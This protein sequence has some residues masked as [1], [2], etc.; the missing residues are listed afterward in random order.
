VTIAPHN[1]PQGTSVA[2]SDD[3]LT[4]AVG[5][6]YYHGATGSDSGQVRIYRFDNNEW[7][8]LGNAI[9]GEDENNVSVRNTGQRLQ[10]M[11]IDV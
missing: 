3:G 9:D 11:R 6:A 2:L 10:S 5:A 1:T 7:I 4:L 8:Q